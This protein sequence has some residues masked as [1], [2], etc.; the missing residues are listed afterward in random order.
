LKGLDIPVSDYE[1]HFEEE[2]QSYS[3]TL[4]SILNGS[5]YFLTGPLAR[6]NLNFHML[7]PEARKLSKASKLSQNCHNPFKSL[8]VRMIETF[9]ACEEAIRLIDAYRYPGII[10]DNVEPRAGEGNWV[11]EAPRGILYHSYRIDNEGLIQEARI[12]A[13]TS[14]NQKIMEDDL[15]RLVSENLDLSQEVLTHRCEQSI[16]NYDPCISCSTHFLKLKIERA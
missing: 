9:Y 13:P 6:Y 11:T 7:S 2:H 8:L 15:R 10:N 1:G 3:T 16:R 12:V 4:H 14:H 5:R